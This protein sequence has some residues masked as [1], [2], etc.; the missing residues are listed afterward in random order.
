MTVTDGRLS[1]DQAVAH[2]QQGG[3]CAFAAVPVF[4]EDGESAEGAKVFIVER[5]GQSGHR[6]RFIA[7]PFFST[8]LAA[9]E[10][11]AAGEIPERVR[12]LRFLPSALHEEWCSDQIQLLIG[13]L[14]QA[15]NVLAPEMPDYVGMPK[16]AAAPEVSFPVSM[17]GR[18]GPTQRDG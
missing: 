16:R 10:I 17:I 14:M 15:S 7:G 11:M 12:L 5:D 18:P 6:V 8:A 9:D 4:G 2:V 13:K 3:Q 1:F